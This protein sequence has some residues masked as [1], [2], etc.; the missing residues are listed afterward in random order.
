LHEKA[1]S[2]KGPRAHA[3]IGVSQACEPMTFE[4]KEAANQGGL[5]VL[6]ERCFSAAYLPRFPP[7]QF[8]LPDLLSQLIQF[9]QLSNKI[10]HGYNALLKR[11]HSKI[12]CSPKRRRC[13]GLH[14][15]PI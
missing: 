7:R 13:A 1:C 3:M 9:A 6:M 14:L 4:M 15:P 12:S 11:T 5:F 2:V 8:C 10:K